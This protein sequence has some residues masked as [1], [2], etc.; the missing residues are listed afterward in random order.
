MLQRL[1]RKP[2]LAAS[3]CARRSYGT[4]GLAPSRARDIDL[5]M[6]TGAGVSREFGV[7]GVKLPLMGDWSDAL[8]NK[9]EPLAHY[10]QATGLRR[11]MARE[12]LGAQPG[13]FP[14]KTAANVVQRDLPG[15]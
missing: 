1:F 13:T 6:V 11:Q 5:V 3:I 4:R 8:G 12:D 10:L 2:S 15:R 7:N 9:L 14:L